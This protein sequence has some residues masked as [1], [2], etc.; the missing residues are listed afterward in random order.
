MSEYVIKSWKAHRE[1]DAQTG[2]YAQI[3]G[4]AG[5]LLSWILA[6]LSI[7]PTVSLTVMENKILFEQGSLEGSVK[8]VIPMSKIS[9]SYYGYTKPWKKAIAVG[10]VC[11][12]LTFLVMGL[13][14]FAFLMMGLSA[15]VGVV[16]YFLNK[17]LTIGLVEVSGVVSSID[18]KRSVIEGQKID[19]NQAREICDVIES[20]VDRH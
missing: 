14:A 5:G 9:S 7:D 2:E 18:F 11:V 3:V 13:G 1:P 20:L 19:E 12:A 6:Q 8:R 16:Y 4:R 17:I 15:S 10:V